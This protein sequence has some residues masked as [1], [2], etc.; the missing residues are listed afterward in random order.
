MFAAKLLLNFITI[1]PV[2]AWS[3]IY[4]ATNGSDRNNG[5][6]EQ[7]FGS[8]AMAVR[9]ARELRRLGDPSIERGIDIIVEDG[10]YKLTEPLFIRPEDSGTEESPTAIKAAEGAHPVLSGGLEIHG[11][12]KVQGNAAAGLPSSARGRVWVADVPSIE[13]PFVPF[14]QLWI[15]GKK[16]IRAK[17]QNGDT[18][19]RIRSWDHKSQSCWI[20]KPAG[21][22]L[23]GAK[24]TEMFI[25]QWWAIAVLRVKSMRFEGDSV[26]LTFHQP[27]SRI[28]S[29]HPWPAPWISEETGNSAF[30][31]TNALEFLDEP[32]EWYLDQQL[33]KV[34][35]FPRKDEN[36]NTASVVAPYLET[37]VR[38]EGTVDRPVRHVAFKG[39]SFQNTGCVR[40]SEQGHVALQDGM[41]F[42]DAYKL[43]TPGT[44]NKK[45]LENQAWVGRPSAAAEVSFGENISFKACSFLHLASTALDYGKGVHSSLIS[46]NL[47]KDVGG[48]AIL[49]GLFSE[50]A[51]EAHLPYLP[52]D[53]REVTQATSI[54]NNLINE[55]ANEDWGCVGIGV[56]FVS[57]CTIEHNDIS[58]IPYSGISLGWGWTADKNVMENNS[59]KANRVHRYA[60]QMYDAAGIYTLSAQPG[61]VISNNDVDSV[62]KAPYAH[63]PSHWFYIYTDEGTSGLTV[64]NNWTSSTKFLQNANGPGNTWRNNGPMVN[65]S[66]T[67]NAGLQ[68]PFQYLLKQKNAFDRHLKI[69]HE[70][71]VVIELVSRPGKPIDIQKLRKLLRDNDVDTSAIYQWKTHYVVFD[72]VND[73]SVLRGRI[74]DAFPTITTKVYYDPFYEFNKKNCIDT[75]T[76]RS[77]EHV[78]L[79]ANLVADVKKQKEYLD[80]HATQ[81]EQWPEVSKGFCNADFQRLLVYKTGRQLMLVISIPK[82]ESLDRLNPRTTENNPRVIEWNKIMSKYQEGIEGTKAGETWVFFKQIN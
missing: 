43:K 57:N 11:W 54:S 46:G 31:L 30:Y 18:M 64:E 26:Q 82:G 28:E 20:P 38:I 24:G 58:D 66:V 56:G 5:T 23:A 73:A 41:F 68:Q 75:T 60:R 6:K 32:G 21:V 81:F 59:V 53:K 2:A 80:Y 63:L 51:M 15:N 49:C 16:G 12:K 48:T 78:V 69:N 13:K 42:I 29:E 34:Y 79:T 71:P 33:R 67:G 9:K 19:S 3:Q 76:A 7:P 35:Y 25:H 62:Y 50:P 39:I 52:N 1:L 8:V 17:A 36:L 74:Q 22:N 27:E 70:Q 45:T 37:L 77:W 40:P 47:F 55:V 72:K 10:T 4:V 14:R 61:T 65:D 44:P